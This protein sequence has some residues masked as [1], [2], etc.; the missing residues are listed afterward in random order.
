MEAAIKYLTIADKEG[1]F[2]DAMVGKS[3]SDIREIAKD[4]LGASVFWDY[5]M[6]RTRE[7][8]YHV[9]SGLGPAIKRA[10]IFAPYA[11]LVWLETKTPDIE[12]ERY[13]SRKIRETYPERRCVHNLSP[14]LIGLHMGLAKRA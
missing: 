14:A 11:D 3:I 2:K 10:T 5:K 1:A 9:T 13:F 7:G 8:Y 6:S 4:V 12:E